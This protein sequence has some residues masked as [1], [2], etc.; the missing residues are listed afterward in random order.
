MAR[1]ARLVVAGCP[2]VIEQRVSGRVVFAD[3]TDRRTYLDAVAAVAPAAGMAPHAYALLADRV[4]L[5][6]TPRSNTSMGNFMQRVNRRYVSAYNARNGSTGS[7]W[8]GRYR[9]SAV[10]AGQAL[11][12]VLRWIEQAPI[13]FGLA[14]SAEQFE[15]SSASH[16]LGMRREPFL[17]EMAGFWQLGNTP[18]EREAAYLGL[19]ERPI[20]H[21]ECDR[22]ETALR[23][24]WPIGTQA[25]IDSVAIAQKRAA[26]P[27][28]RGRPKIRF[29]RSME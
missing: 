18:F 25:F 11:V 5:L 22:I 23:G 10:E 9:A 28:P 15:G 29:I 26:R 7:V 2:H 21:F 19:L 14:D 16:H 4:L 17:D 24:G 20:D 1:V 6:A 8:P 12:T 27:A 13:R 3:A